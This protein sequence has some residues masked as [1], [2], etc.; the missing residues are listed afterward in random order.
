MKGNDSEK[1]Y[2]YRYWRPAVAADN[3]VFRFDGKNL[4]ILLV[5]RKNDPYKGKWAF[6][7]GFM[8]EGETLQQA[9][10]RE[11]KEETGVVP[12][13][14]RELCSQSDP[15]RDPREQVISVVFYS[16]VRDQTATA[17]DDAAEVRW[18]NIYELPELAFDHAEIFQKAIDMIRLTIRFDP[19]FFCLLDS[20]FTLPDLCRLW[21]SAFNK[22]F[23]RRNFQK[24]WTTFSL[25]TNIIEPVDSPSNTKTS[26]RAPKFYKFNRESYIKFRKKNRFHF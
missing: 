19:A 8:E 17:N 20:E 2:C 3:A 25:L 22:K 1:S 11:L 23:D 26:P 12:E 6:P 5:R 10:L 9:A 4:Q 13:F 21:S 7:G 24:H 14:T 18:F 16:F 15:H